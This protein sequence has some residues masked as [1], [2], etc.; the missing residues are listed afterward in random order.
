MLKIVVIVFL[1]TW[2]IITRLVMFVIQKPAKT[3]IKVLFLL[4]NVNY[5][6]SSILIPCDML[7]RKQC[8]ACRY[9]SSSVL[10]CH[11]HHITDTNNQPD[12]SSVKNTLP[13]KN[14]Q[15]CKKAKH[16]NCYAYFACIFE[17]LWVEGG[18][19]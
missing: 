13:E 9:T 8:N 2:K 7:T 19:T 12:G 14:Q 6:T 3:V 17:Q 10:Y 15:K 11:H 4:C 5:L 16:G 1:Q 18:F